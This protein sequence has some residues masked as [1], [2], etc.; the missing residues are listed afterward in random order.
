MATAI[1]AQPDRG[2]AAPT[3]VPPSGS[4]TTPAANTSVS[5]IPLDAGAKTGGTLVVAQVS[6]GPTFSPWEEAAGVAFLPGHMV[7][8]MIVQFQSW[9][10]FDDTA[11]GAYW[12]IHPDLATS[13][14]QSADGLSWTFRFRDGVTIADGADR[15]PFTCADAKWS[16]DTIRTADG[17]RRS[18]RAVHFIAINDIQCAD[19]LTMVINLKTP[20][21]G[22]LEMIALPY[23][24]IFPKYKYD[25]KTDDLR[26]TPN[27]GTGPFTLVQWIPG[28]KYT[29]AARDDYWNAP[30]PYLDGVDLLILGSNAQVA[31]LRAGRLDMGSTGGSQGGA[32]ANTLIKE[33]DICT[34]SPEIINVG[35]SDVVH[36]NHT[37]A[38][39]NTPA[40]KNA[41]SLAIDRPKTV[42]LM[43]DGWGEVPSC[44][45]F[46]PG[47]EWCMPENVLKTI[48]GYDM[49]NVAAN[50][51]QARKLL[52]DA[53]FAPGDL[54]VKLRWWQSSAASVPPVAIIEDLQAIGIDAVMEPLETALAYDSLSNAEFDLQ[55]HGFFVAGTDPDVPLFEHFYSGSDRNYGRYSN[56][57]VDRMID[58][59]SAAT[60]R[61]VRKQLAWDIGEILLRD[62]AK[63]ISRLTTYVVVMNKDMKNNMPAPAAIATYGSWNRFEHVW[64]DR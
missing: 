48:P 39:W 33:C 24:A 5:G 6:E 37:R 40:V 3:A 57:E 8:N 64:L 2:Q 12:N 18:P 21:A 47:T 30:F 50:Q 41:I 34:I 62:Q 19:D 43:S 46:H 10:D 25:G 11:A 54:K 4:G 26:N 14:E 16:L 56:P 17:L 63:I 35:W 28:E 27:V 58:E 9:G 51:E 1:V 31:A 22:L 36:V 49:Q 23:H 20:K 59:M 55:V 45:V 29:F 53:G 15:I 44:G 60:D 32:R 52:A 38:P 61:E 42:E 13:W 7:S